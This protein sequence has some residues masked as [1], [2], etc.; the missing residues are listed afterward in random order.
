M[1]QPEQKTSAL[2]PWNSFLACT[3]TLG[4]DGTVLPPRAESIEDPQTPGVITKPTKHPLQ[5]GA[6]LFSCFGTPDDTFPS[7][8][9]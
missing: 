4:I 1:L 6:F 8:F 7:Y 2:A 9:K 5:H 3:C